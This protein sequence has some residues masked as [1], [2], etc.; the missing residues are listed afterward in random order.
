MAQ[1][2][3]WSDMLIAGEPVTFWQRVYV[4]FYQA[5]VYKDRWLQYLNGVKTTLLVTAMALLIGIVLG[6]IV[7]VVRTAHDQ[8]RDRKSVV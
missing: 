8:Q 2:E 5:F 3:A 6:L 4:Y 1:F 7:A